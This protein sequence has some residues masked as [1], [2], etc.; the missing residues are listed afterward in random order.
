MLGEQ[1][2]GKKRYR[3]KV[4]SRRFLLNF[5]FCLSL[6]KSKKLR[7]TRETSGKEKVISKLHITLALGALKSGSYD[8]DLCGG[9]GSPTSRLLFS[10]EPV[11]GRCI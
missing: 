1:I 9:R 2:K 8:L 10:H 7:H 11:R 3:D 6:G 5:L 4:F